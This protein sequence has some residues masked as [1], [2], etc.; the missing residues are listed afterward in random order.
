MADL[1]FLKMLSNDELSGQKIPNE[2][3]KKVDAQNQALAALY[4]L[5]ELKTKGFGGQGIDTGPVAQYYPDTLSAFAAQLEGVPPEQ[6]ADRAKLR[7]QEL[8]F[9]NPERKDITG[10]QASVQE[11]MKFIYPMIPRESDNDDVWAGKAA[12]AAE[13]LIQERNKTNELLKSQS[14]K[15]P[16]QFDSTFYLNQLKSMLYPKGR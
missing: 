10:A 5:V 2:F 15:D 9:M 11:L 13:N 3:L 1:S 6:R 4:K 7:Q 16:N 12:N 14:F 8:F